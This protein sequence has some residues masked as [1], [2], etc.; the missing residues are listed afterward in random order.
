MKRFPMS[1]SRSYA[2]EE[3]VNKE[4]F[5]SCSN[6]SSDNISVRMGTDTAT[7]EEPLYAQPDLNIPTCS[8]FPLPTNPLLLDKPTKLFSGKH[9]QPEEPGF[10]SPTDNGPPQLSLLL[11]PLS[12]VHANQQTVSICPQPTTST[13]FKDDVYDLEPLTF[14]GNGNGSEYMTMKRNRYSV[15]RKSPQMHSIDLLYPETIQKP[16][17]R[18]LNISKSDGNY[19]DVSAT[20]YK[21][22]TNQ[23]HLFVNILYSVEEREL[24]SSSM[25][26]DVDLGE[27]HVAFHKIQQRVEEAPNRKKPLKPNPWYADVA[28]T[29]KQEK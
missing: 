9:K 12:L 3:S 21:R 10:Y 2:K 29:K 4:W 28:S 15:A 22:T 14:Y 17:H 23:K 5:E 8:S 18:A 20:N 19:E 7:Y 11:D 27:K 13:K 26:S 16:M 24:G 6:P 1:K 25:E